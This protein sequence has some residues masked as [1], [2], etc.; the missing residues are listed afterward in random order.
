MVISGKN[1]IVKTFAFSF[2]MPLLWILV[3]Q[4][5]LLQSERKQQKFK[6]TW[7]APWTG[8]SS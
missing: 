7:I 6:N 3:L 2:V 5:F 8:D 1:A 4:V